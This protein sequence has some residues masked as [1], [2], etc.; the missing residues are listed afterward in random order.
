MKPTVSKLELS[1]IS[2]N[3]TEIQCVCKRDLGKVYEMLFTSFQAP[4]IPFEA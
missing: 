3:L 1:P 2:Q 4:R